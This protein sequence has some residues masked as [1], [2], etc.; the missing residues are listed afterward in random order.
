[1]GTQKV[2]PE[3]LLGK[4]VGMT[5]LFA[6]DGT[7]IPVTVIQ[8]GPCFVLDV[9]SNDK[10]GYTGVQL[11]FDPKKPSRCTKPEMGHFAKSGKGAF[12]HVKEIRC[13]NEALGWTTPGQELRVGEV[14]ANGEMV[15]VTGV[16]I[17]RGFAGVV[18]RFKAKGQP[19]TR[20]THEYFRHIGSIGNR[21]TPGHV[22]K[23][24]KM[25][26]HM[27]NEIVTVQNLQVVAVNVEE[28]L[29][30]VKG[31][32]PGSKNALLV[33]KKAMKS[34]APNAQKAQAA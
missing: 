26:G 34:Y 30:M 3:G 21:K 31:G 15:D 16:S 10:N 23:N 32:T 33:I 27:G 20:G 5:Q 14:F 7:C 22:F 19:A 6:E 11:G 29:L 8:V 13:D 9:R 17:G 4:K 18:K 25:P 28:N 24:K 2:F 12:Y 1:M